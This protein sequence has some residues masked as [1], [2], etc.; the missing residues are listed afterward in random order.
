M[1]KMCY[2]LALL[3]A[4]VCFP[5]TALADFDAALFGMAGMV[6]GE[7]A[8]VSVT[9]ISAPTTSPIDPC[10][11][12]LSFVDAAGNTILNA[13]SLPVVAQ[14]TVPPGTSASL[15]LPAPAGAV[16]LAQ[17]FAYRAVVRQVTTQTAPTPGCILASSH[18][19]FNATSGITRVGIPV[20]PCQPIDP[21]RRTNGFLTAT[22][23]GLAGVAPGQTVRFSAVNLVLSG[24][25]PPDPCKVEL[26]FVGINGQTLKNADGLPI[27]SQI[28]LAPGA[29]T[30]LDFQPVAVDSTSTFGGNLTFA[31]PVIHQIGSPNP[32][33]PQC[34][35][36]TSAELVDSTSGVSGPPISPAEAK[37]PPI[38]PAAANGPPIKL[39]DAALFGMAG[40]VVGQ[41]ARLNVVNLAAPVA[42]PT[43]PCRIQLSFVDAAGNTV[44][45]ADAQPMLSQVTV[46]P[47]MAASLALSAPSSAVG[48]ANRFAYRPVV[49]YLSARPSQG[50][51]IVASHEIHDATSGLIKV[52]TPADPMFEAEPSWP[53]DPLRG[54]FLAASPIGAFGVVPGQTVRFSA[55]N[56]V[57]TASPGD[58]CRVELRL[59]GPDGQT[60]VNSAGNPLTQQVVLT[61]GVASALDFA[62]VPSDTISTFGSN[63]TLAR[64]VI[65]QIGSPNPTAP[66]CAVVTSTEL[67]DSTSGL[68]T[69]VSPPVLPIW[70]AAPFMVN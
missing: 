54:Q 12:E 32:T 49:R 60:L 48:L 56:L 59:V 30:S 45:N 50:C 21:C 39:A 18:E 8:R 26:S 5:V 51:S 52:T 19:I 7:T 28:T 43:D 67:V 34:A 63:V 62:P 11:A 6:A 15:T 64:A 47:G 41:A 31:Q 16:G 2:L 14:V 53:N 58:P 68:T 1:K 20:D 13:D 44:V 70:P 9:N 4:I 65:R 57:P 10:R 35:I 23:L 27:L 38:A 40:L 66:Q 61:P 46:P 22:P 36:V 24:P 37:G 69:S 3:F 25:Y 42:Y 29:S 33:A 55:V 17:R